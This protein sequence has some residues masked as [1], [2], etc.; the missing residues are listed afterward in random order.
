MLAKILF[1]AAVVG[2][3][4]AGIAAIVAAF[5]FKKYVFIAWGITFIAGSIISAATASSGRPDGG[6][7]PP[8]IGAI[9]KGIPGWAWGIIA[10][11]VVISGILTFVLPP[12]KA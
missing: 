10:S 3:I 6:F 8:T 7:S 2:G 11:M 12:W 9:F 4:I 5:V 1:W